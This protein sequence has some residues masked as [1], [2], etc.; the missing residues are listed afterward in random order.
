MC[1]LGF[2]IM[3]AGTVFVGVPGCGDGGTSG[4]G[5]DGGSTGGGSTS[6][7][8][9]GGSTS[10]SSSTSSSPGTVCEQLCTVGTQS[11]CIQS[12]LDKCIADCDKIMVDYPDCTSELEAYY[13]CAA[14]SLDP[15]SCDPQE[16]CP[17]Q[18]K[19]AGK[20]TNP[21]CEVLDC[22]A[23]EST[24]SCLGSCYGEP[25]EAQCVQGANGVSCTCFVNGQEIGY[26]TDASLT[27]DL[28]SGCCTK[29][30]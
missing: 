22:G 4:G 24:C 17:L 11:G 12:T 5:G 16:L 29:Y 6:S 2:S 1:K 14:D 26:C 30:Y 21:T 23:N 3:L 25:V 13:Q 27:C 9:A 10:G 28:Q 8:S 20:C 7:T 19:A 18:A 15:T